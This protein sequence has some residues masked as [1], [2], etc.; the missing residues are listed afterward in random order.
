MLS[1]IFQLNGPVVIID[2]Y[3]MAPEKDEKA[4]MKAVANQ[5]VSIGI[6]AGGKDFQFYSEV[7]KSFKP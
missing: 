1:L 6:D 4:L 5:S 3:E 7:I 2:D